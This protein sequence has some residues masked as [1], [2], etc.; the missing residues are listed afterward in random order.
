MK[1]PSYSG[2]DGL[3]ERTDAGLTTTSGLSDEKAETPVTQSAAPASTDAAQTTQTM[4]PDSLEI[5]ELLQTLASI[6]PNNIRAATATNITASVDSAAG[7]R[8]GGGGYSGGG[9]GGSQ[10]LKLTGTLSMQ[11]LTTAILNAQT[12]TPIHTDGGGAPLMPDGPQSG[13]KS[14]IADLAPA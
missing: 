5:P 4:Q 6:G 8:G 7:P 14:P 1:P 2:S 3:K 12:Q 11:G 10:P 9:G 13:S